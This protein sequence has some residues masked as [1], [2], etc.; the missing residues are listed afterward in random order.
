[1]I[2][3]N[4]TELIGSTPLL[5]LER[6]GAGLGATNLDYRSLYLNFENG[7]WMYG[8]RAVAEVKED[9][10]KTLSLCREMR[11]DDCECSG[12]RKLWQEFLRLF[13]PLM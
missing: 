5:R 1:M 10:L 12:L 7:V 6:F 3:G 13:A 4:I 9:F 2:Y 11:E 8:S